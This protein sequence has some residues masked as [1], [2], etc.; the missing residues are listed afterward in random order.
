[1]TSYQSQ[2]EIAS[3]VAQTTEINHIEVIENV[4]HSLEQGDGA[5]VSQG[6]EGGYLWKF[7]YGSVEVFVQLTGTT[8][9]DN[10]R[11]WSVVLQLPSKDEPKLMRKL[12]EMNASN[13]FESRFSII[14]NEVAVFGTHTLTDLSAS[15]VSRLITVVANVADSN[16]Q[17]LHSEFATV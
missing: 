5:M 8:D 1:M 10:L 15:E 14:N 16:C 17:A 12:L 11:V 3:E 7:K 4:I 2:P 13:T 9:E 6:S